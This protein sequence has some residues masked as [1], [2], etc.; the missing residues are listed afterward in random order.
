MLSC[1]PET[2]GMKWPAPTV[3]RLMVSMLSSWRS[4]ACGP[5]GLV[6]RQKINSH[7][8]LVAFSLMSNNLDSESRQ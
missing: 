1:Y 2:V 8:L 7:S 4:S 3:K 6:A 5:S